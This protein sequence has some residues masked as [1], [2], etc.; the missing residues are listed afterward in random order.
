VVELLLL[1]CLKRR[2][3]SEHPPPHTLRAV[4]REY[5][6]FL[7]AAPEAPAQYGLPPAA[8]TKAVEHLA[9][10]G[11]VKASPH[12]GAARAGSVGAISMDGTGMQL[13]APPHA[14][15]VFVAGSNTVPTIVKRFSAGMVV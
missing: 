8:L 13:A 7:A 15:E 6:A 2:T 14:L 10:L 9:A 12:G 3:D 1:L 5:D 4:L 11:L